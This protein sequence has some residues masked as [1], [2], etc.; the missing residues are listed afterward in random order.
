[1]QYQSTEEESLDRIIKKKNAEKKENKILGSLGKLPIYKN[2]CEILKLEKIVTMAFR[3]L[4]EE[5][6]S[7][8]IKNIR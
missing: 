7:A 1:M 4:C 8:L 5:Q 3:P 2:I 6:Q